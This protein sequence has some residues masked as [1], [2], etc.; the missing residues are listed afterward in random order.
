MN[1]DTL[2]S[3]APLSGC[4]ALILTLGLSH[5]A[6][7]QD[8]P[9]ADAPDQAK[10]ADQGEAQPPKDARP[11]EDDPAA[12]RKFEVMQLLCDQFGIKAEPQEGDEEIDLL[13]ENTRAIDVRNPGFEFTYN[14]GKKPGKDYWIIGVQEGQQGYIRGGMTGKSDPIEGWTAGGTHCAGF[15]SGRPKQWTVSPDGCTGYIVAQ[16]RDTTLNQ[17]LVGELQPNTRYTLIVEV[18]KRN[19]YKRAEQRELIVR[20]TDGVGNDLKTQQADYFITPADPETGFSVSLVSLTT[21]DEQPKGDLK[22]ILGMNASGSV[23]ANFDNVRLWA[24]PAK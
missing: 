14:D 10:A 8:A 12:Y 2:A 18:F 24:Q 3:G 22:I 20:L 1:L 4:L 17:S 15:E 7:A 5:H 9:P 6:A 13:P 16:G 19:D 21:S 23:R 11:S